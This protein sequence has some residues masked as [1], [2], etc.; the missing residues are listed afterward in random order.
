[1]NILIL[2]T[3]EYP[4]LRLTRDMG[5]IEVFVHELS[6]RLSEQN[7]NQVVITRHVSRTEFHETIGNVNIFRVPYIPMRLLK[8]PTYNFF[9]FLMAFFVLKRV[10]I[11]LIY[12]SETVAGFFASFLKRIFK[13]PW[14]SKIGTF[15]SRQPE[16][17]VFARLILKYFERRTIKN[18]D[19]VIITNKIAFQYVQKLCKSVDFEKVF[20][21]PNAVEFETFHAINSVRIRRK[22]GFSDTDFIILFVGRF[23]E[24]KGIIFL[25]KAFQELIKR[26]DDLKHKFKLVLVGD[27][28]LFQEIKVLTH[29]ESIRD[30]VLFTGRL[31]D[32]NSLMKISSIFCLP[33]VYEAFPLV[34]LEAMATGLPVIAT[35]VGAVPEI[36]T[37]G[38][39]GILV[40]IK[41]PK[42]IADAILSLHEDQS[43]YEKI[44]RNA[45]AT[46][47]LFGWEALI[48]R[49]LNVFSQAIQK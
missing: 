44:K 32:V 26:R 15:G 41:D 9:A 8:S 25:V 40:N 3:K 49:Y 27:G 13:I 31:R 39:N 10:K 43:F 24:S 33:S 17:P 36:I 21:I 34:I 12:S 6:R 4:A 19:K 45:T 18:S 11:D 46:A 7:I 5:G 35:K 14:V 30:N 28:P 42:N 16:W 37:N 23:T 38:Q 22:L 47:K 48:E 1:M 20:V 29:K 2:G